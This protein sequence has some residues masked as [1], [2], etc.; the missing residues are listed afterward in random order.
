MMTLWAGVMGGQG[1]WVSKSA[2][3][4]RLDSTRLAPTAANLA[5]ECLPATGRRDEGSVFAPGMQ[6][7]GSQ[8]ES[9]MPCSAVQVCRIPA[10]VLVYTGGVCSHGRCLFT[11]AGVTTNCNHHSR[12]ASNSGA[13]SSPAA[14]SVYSSGTAS[15]GAAGARPRRG[16][17]G[18]G[19]AARSLDCPVL[20]W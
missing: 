13:C 8:L 1:L 4:Y 6:N 5:R 9:R 16:G 20:D 3:S 7:K 17:L 12:P 2:A 14:V 11:R 18:A 19:K 15:A 10:A